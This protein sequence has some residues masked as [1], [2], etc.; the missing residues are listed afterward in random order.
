[1]GPQDSRTL[2]GDDI[3]LGHKMQLPGELFECLVEEEREV[4]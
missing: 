1:L 3:C 4:L 2:S